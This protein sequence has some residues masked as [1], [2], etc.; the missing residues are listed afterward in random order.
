MPLVRVAV[1]LLALCFATSAAAAGGDVCRIDEANQTGFL[2][3]RLKLPKRGGDALPVSGFGLTATSASLL[4]LS[5]T[6]LRQPDGELL[7]GLTRHFQRCLL[8]FVLDEGLNGTV[9]YDCNLDNANDTTGSVSLI[10]CATLL[11]L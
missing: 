10:D 1:L 5:G 4:P 3:K 7:L 2:L 6:L 9:S 8:G 11:P